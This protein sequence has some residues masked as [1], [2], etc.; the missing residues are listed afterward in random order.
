MVAVGGV[1]LVFRVF[2]PVTDV[3][4]KIWDPLLGLRRAPDQAGRYI[5]G[6]GFVDARYHFNRQGWNHPRDYSTHKPAG[7]RRVCLIGDS[8]VEALQV[9]PGE[10]MFSV[11]EQRMSRPDRP[12]EWYAFGASGWG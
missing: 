6:A 5:N 10:A 8:Y 3:P 12:V 4:H 2:V 7:T 1:E 9:N 11:A